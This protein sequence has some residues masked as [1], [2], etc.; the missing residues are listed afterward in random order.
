MVHQSR[1][2]VDGLGRNTSVV[3]KLRFHTSV[4]RVHSMYHNKVKILGGAL[5][6]NKCEL[7]STAGE[8]RPTG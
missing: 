1:L 2:C 4:K 8:K 3:E 6:K 5:F 7:F